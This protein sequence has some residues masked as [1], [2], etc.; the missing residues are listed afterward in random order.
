LPDVLL[1][2]RQLPEQQSEFSEGCGKVAKNFQKKEKSLKKGVDKS[3][4]V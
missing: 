1:E 4:G 3:K 2:K